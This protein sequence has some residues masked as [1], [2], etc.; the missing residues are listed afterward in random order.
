MKVPNLN[1][2]GEPESK[3][4][5]FAMTTTIKDKEIKALPDNEEIIIVFFK[6]NSPEEV[7]NNLN[8]CMDENP[9]KN[10]PMIKTAMTAEKMVVCWPKVFLKNTKDSRPDPS[11]VKMN[12]IP[13]PVSMDNRFKKIGGT[14]EDCATWL[15]SEA[16][17]EAKF[18]RKV[19]E[20]WDVVFFRARDAVVVDE[21]CGGRYAVD[22]PVGYVVVL[23]D[24][25]GS[26]DGALV[27][28]SI[29]D[30]E[31]GLIFEEGQLVVALPEAV[32]VND[33]GDAQVD[34]LGV[35]GVGADEGQA[36]V[37]DVAVGC[38]RRRRVDE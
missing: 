4:K 1:D 9:A 34:R 28:D 15:N 10:P 11:K 23:D 32:S 17:S 31:T 7:L 37:A 20:A 33:F 38:L 2:L 3:T 26:L 6:L 21:G 13:E 16:D 18:E 14:K 24:F 12:C 35:G 19:A 22:D 5:I 27:H 29:A 25:D 30:S 36:V 8:S